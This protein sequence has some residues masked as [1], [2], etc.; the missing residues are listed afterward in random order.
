MSVD[1]SNEKNYSTDVTPAPIRYTLTPGISSHI[2]LKTLPNAVCTLHREG[3][4]ISDSS[5]T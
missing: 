2:V 1:K 3:Q 4:S 5:F